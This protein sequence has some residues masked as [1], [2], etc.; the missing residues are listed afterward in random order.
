MPLGQVFLPRLKCLYLRLKAKALISKFISQ[1]SV[2][3]PQCLKQRQ[4]LLLH[5]CCRIHTILYPLMSRVRSR[6]W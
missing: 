5:D 2:L 1:V 4:H 6:L 3:L